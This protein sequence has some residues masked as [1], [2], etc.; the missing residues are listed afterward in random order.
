MCTPH[1]GISN[2]GLQPSPHTLVK[3]HLFVSTVACKAQPYLPKGQ[4]TTTLSYLTHGCVCTAPA[5]SLLQ[6]P[7]RPNSFHCLP[8]PLH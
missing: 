1:V 3:P 4:I 2:V 5:R 8:N 7:C 6:P